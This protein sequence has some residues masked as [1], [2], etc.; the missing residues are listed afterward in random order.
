MLSLPVC[1][2]DL[3]RIFEV[4]RLGRIIVLNLRRGLQEI[5]FDEPPPDAREVLDLLRKAE[6]DDVIVDCHDIDFLR[7]TALGFFVTVWKRVAGRDG[8]MAFCHASPKAQEI[9]RAT[10]LDRMWKICDSRAEAMEE[11]EK[12]RMGRSDE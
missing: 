7:S 10:K 12:R 2:M 1:N 6:I 5:E 11:V 9:L 3:A 4:E 8:Q